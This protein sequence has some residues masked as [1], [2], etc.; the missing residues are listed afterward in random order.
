MRK[1]LVYRVKPVAKLSMFS[2]QFWGLCSR[3]VVDLASRVDKLGG[4]YGRDV[5]SLPPVFHHQR[6]VFKSVGESVFPIIPT[7]Y[8]KQQLVNINTYSR[9][10]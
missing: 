7:T 5:I 10:F 9:S 6:S 8:N 3:P 2:G 1:S 4:L